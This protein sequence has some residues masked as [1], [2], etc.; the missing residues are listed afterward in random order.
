MPAGWEVQRDGL[1]APRFSAFAFFSG[2]GGLDFGSPGVDVLGGSG[3]PPTDRLAT[4]RIASDDETGTQGNLG[5]HHLSAGAGG[6]VIEEVPMLPTTSEAASAVIAQCLRDQK[7]GQALLW[8]VYPAARPSQSRSPAYGGRLHKGTFQTFVE[9]IWLENKLVVPKHRGRYWVPGVNVVAVDGKDGHRCDRNM[10]ALTLLVFDA[11]LVGPADAVLRFCR[12]QGMA[13]C[14]YETSG[15]GPGRSKWRLVLPLVRAW[16]VRDDARRSGWHRAYE[17]ASALFG[18]VA[19][20]TGKGFDPQLK[21]PSNPI[22]YGQMKDS[23]TPPRMMDYRVDGKWLDLHAIDTLFPPE[24]KV[25]PGGGFTG[26]DVFTDTV[27]DYSSVPL[28]ERVARAEQWLA[29]NPP[30]PRGNQNSH[31][32]GVHAALALWCGALLP[33]ATAWALLCKWADKSPGWER[34]EVE[35]FAQWARRRV[36]GPRT[37]WLLKSAVVPRP[38]VSV[39]GQ[40]I[41]LSGVV[42]AEDEI[43]I[44]EILDHYEAIRPRS[45]FEAEIRLPQILRD[46]L[47]DASKP[48]SNGKPRLICVDVDLGT[49]KTRKGLEEVIRQSGWI[50]TGL[51]HQLLAEV[52][53]RLRDQGI[54]WREARGILAWAGKFACKNPRLVEWAAGL[55]HSPRQVVCSGCPTRKGCVA[56]RGERGHGALLTAPHALAKKLSD[57]DKVR[58][59]IVYDE[60]PSLLDV[61]SVA[62]E[63]LTR[64]ILGSLS[65]APAV[66]QWAASRQIVADLLQKVAKEAQARWEKSA[67]ETAGFDRRW[68]GADLQILVKDVL[69]GA[70]VP[71]VPVGDVPVPDAAGLHAAGK[72]PEGVPHVRTD[73]AIEGILQGE[74]GWTL[75]AG[76]AGARIEW[77]S[78]PTRAPVPAVVLDATAHLYADAIRAAWPDH[79]VEFRRLEVAP[80]T[81]A[82][83]ALLKLS[84]R[85]SRTRYRLSPREWW[86]HMITGISEGV[87]EHGG[88]DLKVGVITHQPAA[89]WLDRKPP[90]I[91]GVSKL[92]TLYYGNCRGSNALEDVDVL[93]TVGDPVPDLGAIAADAVALDVQPSALAWGLTVAEVTQAQGRARAVRRTAA[94][95]VTL[96]HVGRCRPEGP[97]W[98]GRF[99]ASTVPTVSP[100]EAVLLMMATFG[101]VGRGLAQALRDLREEGVVGDL[102]DNSR[103][104]TQLELRTSS[105]NSSPTIN[106]ADPGRSTQKGLPDKAT[107]DV[108]LGVV[109]AASTDQV[110][111]LLQLVAPKVLPVSH[112][113]AKRTGK[114][115]RPWACWCS[116]TEAAIRLFAAI[117][118][119][120]KK[121]ST[122]QPPVDQHT[123][124]TPTWTLGQEL[125]TPAPRGE[126]LTWR[127]VDPSGRPAEPVDDDWAKKVEKIEL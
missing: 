93:V 84:S 73:E 2:E 61:W 1:H 11:D 26:G 9:E 96:V 58:T 107:L 28:P 111:R 37:G 67:D 101:V 54:H 44:D 97:G 78:I 118:A 85:V 112:T 80:P 71:V 50:W 49:G 4:G 114:A 24:P 98:A 30:P 120:S 113:P 86:R 119:G 8:T 105:S 76:E 47:V 48:S 69:A 83:K 12:K 66:V 121:D 23:S 79:D 14:W 33:D 124:G 42:D 20:L 7:D 22:Y 29:E 46:A 82:A 17:V 89:K 35:R 27:G 34:L 3:D 65:G 70:P 81:G 127:S 6:F 10:A 64:P 103:L 106:L 60:Q 36:G 108:V 38:P 32:A 77:R 116:S 109:A 51:S 21:V 53:E 95:P 57:Q 55:G 62:V 31:R 102:P 19:G 56:R 125:P 68:S 45:L 115:G 123:D 75:V 94:H 91:P 72:P 92:R 63:D 88:S 99:L 90:K 122:V 100:Q 40:P 87:K 52:H 5:A 43:D 110:R 39:D 16:D 59:G 126:D 18:V 117:D 74:Q 41:D 13:Y 25:K 104:N 15:A